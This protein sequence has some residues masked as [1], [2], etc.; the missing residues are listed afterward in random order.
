MVRGRRPLSKELLGRREQFGKLLGDRRQQL[1]KD[2]R[3]TAREI[4]EDFDHTRLTKIEKGQRPVP[5]ADLYGMA[6]AYEVPWEALVLA[7]S[8]QLPL[9]LSE[10][11]AT[12]RDQHLEDRTE[13]LE[14][15]LTSEEKYQLEMYLGYL[16][17]V[18]DRQDVLSVLEGHLGIGDRIA[19][20]RQ[21]RP[22]A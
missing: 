4:R 15:R 16:R 9:P 14:I 10:T 18:Q 1:N 17:F 7:A 3:G 8:G 12:L 21:K 20:K 19:T 6:E 11:A 22:Q 2:L 5:W 13:Q